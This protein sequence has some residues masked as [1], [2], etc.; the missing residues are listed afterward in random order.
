MT[1]ASVVAPAATPSNLLL[2]V[3]DINPFE[4]VVATPYVELTADIVLPDIVILLPAVNLF[5]LPFHI[6]FSVSVTKRLLE[7]CV[8]I[9]AGC[10]LGCV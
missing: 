3:L 1:V 5:C 2:S 10:E 8:I 4:L 9:E 6:D 7:F